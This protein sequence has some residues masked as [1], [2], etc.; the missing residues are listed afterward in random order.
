MAGAHDERPPQEAAA[1][2]LGLS[3]W[4]DHRRPR[5]S[6]LGERPAGS[7][8]SRVWHTI[9]EMGSCVE[10]FRAAKGLPDKT[11]GLMMSI[12]ATVACELME[13]AA[14]DMQA[15]LALS[16]TLREVVARVDANKRAGGAA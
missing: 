11:W 8:G 3:G 10:A 12:T 14:D 5:L 15:V 13:Q 16:P 9:R 1:C 7:P 4:P 6:A 2:R